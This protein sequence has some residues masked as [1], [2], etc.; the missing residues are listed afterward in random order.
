VTEG[1]ELLDRDRIAA[2]CGGGLGR[3][4]L[5]YRETA[6]TN[7]LATQLAEHG[8]AEGMVVFAERQTA[9]RGQFGRKW[10]SADG[11]GLWF[12]LLLRPR[13][14]TTEW[15]RITSLVAVSVS[16]ALE[17]ETGLAMRI[18]PPNDL[19]IGIRK[20]VGVLTEART[21]RAPFA[22]VGIGVNVN[23]LQ[24]DFP[25]ELQASATSLR[26]EKGVWIE[27]EAV[28]VAIL[29]ELNARYSPDALPDGAVDEAFR[30][31]SQ[32]PICGN[33]AA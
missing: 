29:R 25:L 8:E 6:S 17:A 20:V 11:A 3:N 5:V 26:I 9:G 15:K 1:F 31:L 13:W 28:A 4:V 32:R 33:F 16:Q 14:P 10:V 23:Q 21:G 18:K 27:R 19:Y 30:A 22:V 24:E 7:D 12:S 2:G